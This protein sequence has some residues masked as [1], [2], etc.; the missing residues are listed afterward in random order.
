ML[1]LTVEAKPTTQPRCKGHTRQET[2]QTT[3][4]AEL[5]LHALEPTPKPH[6]TQVC[7]ATQPPAKLPKQTFGVRI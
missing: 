3:I 1:G 6:N 7:N 4:G 2:L 5:A